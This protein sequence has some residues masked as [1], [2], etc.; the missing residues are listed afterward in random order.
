MLISRLKI[1]KINKISKESIRALGPPNIN[2]DS[3]R[4]AT[5]ST[6]PLEKIINQANEDVQLTKRKTH[7]TNKTR[8]ETFHT[9]LQQINQAQMFQFQPGRL[10]SAYP[11]IRRNIFRNICTDKLTVLNWIKKHRGRWHRQNR[12]IY[13]SN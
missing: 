11:K 12:H 10:F 6:G 9:V 1:H 8:Q 3:I 13:K 2:Q 4:E 5:H 7:H